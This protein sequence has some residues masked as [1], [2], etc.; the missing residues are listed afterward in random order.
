[1]PQTLDLHAAQQHLR[2]RYGRTCIRLANAEASPE[3]RMAVERLERLLETSSPM[4]LALEP[5]QGIIAAVLR[6]A[7][8]EQKLVIMDY[9]RAV[10]VYFAQLEVVGSGALGE[11]FLEHS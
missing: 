2:V 5:I 10:W 6:L 8:K 11:V 7:A 9:T 1:M 3:V 4:A